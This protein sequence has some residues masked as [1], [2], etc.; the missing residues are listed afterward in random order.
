MQ[1]FIQ[2]LFKHYSTL[3]YKVLVALILAVI[4][5]YLS[6]INALEDLEYRTLDY[7]FANVQGSSYPDTSLIIVAI[8]NG[9]LDFFEKNGIYWHWPRSFHGHLTKFLTDAGARSIVFDI[10]FDSP[11]LDRA[12]SYSEETDGAFAQAMAGSGLAVLGAELNPDSLE[13]SYLQ[14]SVSLEYNAAGWKEALDP[15]DGR[16][17]IDTLFNAAASIGLTNIEPD[18]DGI[19]RRIS[20]LRQVGGGYVPCLALGA[21]LEMQGISTIRSSGRHIEVGDYIIPVDERGDYLINWYGACC[22]DG[23]FRYLPYAAVIQSA[24]AIQ[25]GQNPV[26]PPWVFKDKIVIIGTD[27]SGLR[28]LRPTPIMHEGMHPGM[29]IWATVLSNWVQNNHIIHVHPIYTLLLTLLL[30]SAVLYSFDR[31]AAWKAYLVLLALTLFLFILVGLLWRGDNRIFLP[32]V[33]PGLGL[34]LAYLFVFSNE[35]RERV[36]LHQVFGAYVSPELME[37]MIETHEIPELGGEDIEGSAF[38]SDLQGFTTLSESMEAQHLIEFLNELFTDLTDIL[39]TNRG[40]LDKYEGDAILAFFGAPYPLD[41]HGSRAV[42]VAIAMQERLAELREKWTGEGDRWPEAASRLQMRIGINSGPMVVG[43]MGSTGRM[44]YT[45]IG[46]TVN[47][48]SRLEQAAKQFGILNHI[49]AATAQDLPSGIVLRDLGWTR[50][51]GKQTAIH[52]YEV[53]GWQERLS[54]QELSLVEGWNEVMDLVQ[55]REWEAAETS[56]HQCAELETDYIGR[57]TTPSR[58]YLEQNL[59]IWRQESYG[60]DWRPIIELRRK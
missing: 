14:G 28:D 22:A 59:P 45:M 49:S 11:D 26:I 12:E 56:L 43:N 44:N 60:E 54:T 53:L 13:F 19:V 16:L 3:W 5:F 1:A 39:M 37:L 30:A 21:L 57:P 31:F 55:H 38:F 15:N 52:T 25:Y 58:V 32:V 46:D 29:E 47:V 36:F 4:S 48:A 7:R 42:E 41:D 8:D 10:L 24:S 6:G 17:P 50:L 34:V 2:A 9:S 40:T 35:M 51:L 20:P 23:V 18:M 27:A 33:T